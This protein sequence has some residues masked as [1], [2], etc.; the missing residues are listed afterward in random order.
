[1]RPQF[2]EAGARLAVVTSQ[3]KGAQEFVDAV[4]K[5]GAIYI[6]DDEAFKRALGSRSYK[7][8]WL[9]RPTV[10]KKI[11]S[12]VGSFGQNT[13]D[14]MDAKTQ[15]LGGVFIVKNGEVIYTH[16][17]TPTFDNGNAKE[18]LAAVLG[19]DVNSLPAMATTPRQDAAVCTKEDK[20]VCGM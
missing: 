16:R 6:D 7:Y 15:L 9:L 18:M 11:I 2:D 5:G 10:V 19:T 4:W 3:D 13:V 17:E 20:D 14:S 8:W 1:M 12:Y